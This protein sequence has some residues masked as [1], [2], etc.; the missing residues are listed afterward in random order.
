MTN[1][2]VEMGSCIRGVIARSAVVG[3]AASSHDASN[4]TTVVAMLRAEF[5]T[6]C[7]AVQQVERVRQSA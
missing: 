4:M 3:A 6:P 1:P 2:A 7:E 5:G